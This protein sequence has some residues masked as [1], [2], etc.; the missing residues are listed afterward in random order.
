MNP[1]AI[2]SGSIVIYWSAMVIALGIIAG[3]FLSMALY[4]SVDGRASALWVFL[5]IAIVL[6]V[7]FSRLIHWYCHMEQYAGFFGAL[8]DFSVGSFCLPGMLLGVFIAGLIVGKSK[9][10]DSRFELMDALAPG[11]ALCIA[12][13]RL[14]AL[15][16]SSCRSKIIIESKALQ[17][18]P[19]ASELTSASGVTEYRFATFF[20]QFL[21]MLVV[22]VLLINFW[23]K[24]RDLPMKANERTAGHVGRLFLVLYSVPE[25]V[26]DSTRYDSSFFHFT[27]LKSLN[28]YMGFVSLIQLISAFIILAAIVHYSI[29]SVRGNGLKWYHFVLWIGFLATLG[30]VGA[31]EYLVQRHGDWYLG[32]YAAMSLSCLVMILIEW[33]L[34]LTSVDNDAAY[35]YE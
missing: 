15:F 33:I 16:N 14:S 30:G 5:P 1:I 32:C 21:F 17:H 29:V 6:S 10:C 25:V 22:T 12:F 13:I 34:Y 26:F 7:I 2:Y 24:R 19:L 35:E 3:F 28:P 8:S 20:V 27:F 18:L 4:T 9:L 23:V 31:S 11:E